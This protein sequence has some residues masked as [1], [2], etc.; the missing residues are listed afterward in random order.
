MVH[1]W[2]DS[3]GARAYVAVVGRLTTLGE[4][5]VHL[6]ALLADES[7]RPG[8]PL[9][10]DLR[11]LYG[12]APLAWRG[13]WRRFL[14]THA[15]SLAGCHWAVVLAAED[16]TLFAVFDDA[17]AIAAEY[18]VVL[19]TFTHSEQAHAWVNSVGRQHRP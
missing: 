5:L 3:T 12:G 16:A 13:P 2:M 14:T 19:R 1:H 8:M 4:M 15:R 11:N 17:A 10:E 6:E 9:I 7:W 18:S